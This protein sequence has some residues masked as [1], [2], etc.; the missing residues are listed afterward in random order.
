MEEMLEVVMELLIYLGDIVH[1]L[2]FVKM[3]YFI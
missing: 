2:M 1:L 3:N